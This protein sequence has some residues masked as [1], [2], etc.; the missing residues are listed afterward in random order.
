MH[1][2]TNS[3]S[4]LVCKWGQVKLA[5]TTLSFPSSSSLSGMGSPPCPL[6]FILL[7]LSFF[8]SHVLAE[9]VNVSYSDCFDANANAS[10]KFDISTI[11]AQALH[12]DSLGNYLNLTVLG[13]TPASILESSN[14]SGSLGECR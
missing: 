1:D 14:S 13:N 10:L 12:D 9:P 6:S 4:R 3:R 2:V 5:E 11:Y 8:L 7:F